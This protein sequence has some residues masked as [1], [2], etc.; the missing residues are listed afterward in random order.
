V[1]ERMGGSLAEHQ[2]ILDGLLAGDADAVA[3]VMRAHVVVQGERFADLIATLD[4]LRATT[5][6]AADPA[7]SDPA[8]HT[9]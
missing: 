4:D 9:A 8:L 7:V 1:S 5:A 6:D 2:Q 3:A